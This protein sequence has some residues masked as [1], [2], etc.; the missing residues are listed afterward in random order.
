MQSDFERGYLTDIG[1]ARKR[2]D[3][4]A[5]YNQ[6]KIPEVE[7]DD[8]ESQIEQY[9]PDMA[10]VG[11]SSE[12]ASTRMSMAITEDFYKSHTDDDTTHFSS[13]Q[14]QTAGFQYTEEIYKHP[15]MENEI[16]REL[17]KPLDPREVYL[18]TSDDS[19][20]SLAMILRKRAAMYERQ[21]V[22]LV[23]DEKGRETKPLTW[24]KLYF[25]AEKIAKHIK[26][27]AALYPGDRVC[28]IYQNSEVG[29]F[30][31]ALFGCFLS[32]TV[33][34]PL[35]SSTPVKD[36]VHIMQSTQSHL[37]LMSETVYKH[38]EKKQKVE[39]TNLWPKG[40]NIWK[41]TDMGTYKP[42]K[43]D[44]ALKITD[45]AYI[46]YTKSTTGEW[47]GVVISHRTI[48]NQMKMI[49]TVLGTSPDIKT[50]VVRSTNKQSNV[51]NT[52]MSTLDCRGS[53]GMIVSVLY[54]VYSGNLLVWLHP[55]TAE[56]PGLYANTISTYR[57]SI[58]LTDYD[59]L[60]TIAYN[61]QSFP[62]STRT[63]SKKKVDL[64]CVSW[65]LIDTPLVD[66]EF[67]D[68]LSDRWFKPLGHPNSKRVISPILS[69]PEHGGAIISMRDWYGNE[70]RLGCTFHQK[71]SKK[72][73]LNR[74]ASTT[75]GGDDEDNDD[76]DEGAFLD[77]DEEDDDQFEDEM[78][79][80][81]LSEVYIDKASLS[82][83]SVVVVHDSS[84]R[85]NANTDSN[86]HS[87]YIRVGSFGYPVP[88]ATLALVNPETKVLSGVMEVGEIWV[89]SHCISGGY[90]GIPEETSEIFQAGCEDY[91]GVL[92]IRFVRTGLLGFTYN[93]KVYV[94]GLY[95]DR[96]NQRVTWLDMEK[97]KEEK[98]KEY[99][100]N[101]DSLIDS[102]LI[103]KFIYRYHF[104]S[105]LGKTLQKYLPDVK[106]SAFFNLITNKEYIVICVV[107]IDFKYE[108]SSILSSENKLKFH[109]I[110]QQVFKLLNKY[111]NLRPFNVLITKRGSLSRSLTS[112]R[113]EIANSLT[114]MKFIDGRLPCIYTEFNPYE[115]TG[116]IYHNEDFKGG[117][118][119]PF[120]SNIRQELLNYAQVQNSG[121]DWR[122]ST[123]DI[124][125]EINMNQFTTPFDILKFRA[126]KQQDE[127]AFGQIEGPVL[128]ENKLNN[129]S[130]KK[131][132]LQVFAICS[133]IL[134]KKVLKAGDHVILNFA[135][136]EDLSVALYSCWLA[137]LIPIVISPFSKD[138]KSLDEDVESFVSIIKKFKVKGVFVNNETENA[139]KNKPVSSKLKIVC[140]SLNVI[141]PKTRNINKHSKT[142]NSGQKT[143]SLMENYRNKSTSKLSYDTIW[144]EWDS[145][146]NYEPNYIRHEDL[147]NI[148]FTIKET[149]QMNKYVPLIS[150]GKYTSGMGFIQ[151]CVL[152]VYLGV[153]TFFMTSIEF[154]S[155]T[156]LFYQIISKY[157]IENVF[158]TSKHSIKKNACN[159][160]NLSNL[161]N[162]MIGWDHRP[163]GKL[164]EIFMERF[165]SS[166]IPVGSISNVYGNTIIPMVS[167]R[168]FLNFEQIKLWLDPYGLSRGYISLVN[169]IDSP[170]AIGIYDS[171]V[172]AINT[173]VIIVNPET[174]SQCRIGEYGEIWCSSQ[175]CI[176]KDR[177]VEYKGVKYLRTGEFGF[178]H[179][180]K[181]KQNGK[182]IEIE[183]LF[184][185]GSIESTFEINGLQFF[186]ND[187]E[188]SIEEFNGVQRC[189]VFKHDGFVICLISFDGT[190][191]NRS[192]SNLTSLMV[193]KVLNKF[194][195]NID[196]LTFLQSN[197]L[198][199]SRFGMLQRSTILSSW[200]K[201]K[202]TVLDTFGAGMGESSMLKYV[203]RIE[204]ANSSST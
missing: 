174:L 66:C 63:F 142:N 58:L 47:K 192:L 147:L 186:V 119:S 4:I 141:L 71:H 140:S 7:E 94:L 153:T 198:P 199:V 126:K 108:E 3:A 195:L 171:G 1:F 170:N 33:A 123:L 106:A 146:N 84:I 51:R 149:C 177:L 127:L 44:G 104:S 166:N 125:T 80:D 5:R 20:D 54:S 73:T 17:Q 196:I 36:L 152:G 161:K 16:E 130:W 15:K 155:Y 45:L 190:N 78:N 100:Q 18:P 131:F 8:K 160:I 180:I 74:I 154:G 98:G 112:G 72:L 56:I 32:G 12:R 124:R 81:K 118:W 183:L 35:N 96:I 201:G 57:I 134:E 107:E 122:D 6:A 60:K 191:T 109:T 50:P 2:D 79:S 23:L 38:F 65:C 27:K 203:E 95:E 99:Q 28:L 26:S 64:S 75:G 194:K 121:L 68:I 189:M 116:T 129:T 187:I 110:C 48:I 24:E 55:K 163:D 34:V 39:K 42:S 103:N 179:P 144:I 114:K 102:S 184:N 157:K 92:S 117:V 97:D 120:S 193:I 21:P 113:F 46:D 77:D 76:D 172:V 138:T 165:E 52:I 25:K 182:T 69:L 40:M 135:L 19:I 143:Y 156:S 29:E 200:I 181:K 67:N 162:L 62:Q 22:V 136:C 185:L 133:Y 105:H 197:S 150:C 111:H 115:G 176:N 164:I 43:K 49:S 132:E 137:G 9:Q 53:I 188:K 204:L 61:Y 175:S 41:T 82:T 139:I 13:S 202:L 85:N 37:C 11:T 178:L 59:T 101:K 128:K 89:D 10:T 158:I 83:N 173:E 148:C 30:M 91:Q 31:T 70:D 169:P 167:T 151:S 93:G 88:D 145:D 159:K 14:G 168:S 90:W 86:I 87:K